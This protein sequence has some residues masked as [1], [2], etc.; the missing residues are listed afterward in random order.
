M[1]SEEFQP[2]HYSRLLTAPN[3]SFFLFGVRGSGKSTW[4]KNLG[5][6]LYE[7]NF[8]QEDLYQRFM[9][10][11]ALFRDTVSRVAQTHKQDGLDTWVFI[12]E[13][14][15]IPSL[16]NEVHD[17]IEKYHLKFILTGSSARK[18]K[19][20]GANLL[21]GR[22]LV[23]H[24]YPFVPTEL[25]NDFSL[26]EVLRFGSLP[27]IQSSAPE[28]RK[29]RLRAYVQTYLKEEIQAEALVRNLSGFMRFI[30]IAALFHGQVINISNIARDCGVERTTVS[31]YLEILHDTLLTFQLSAYE[32]KL[33]V[34]ERKHPKLFWVDP[35]IVRA[36]RGDFGPVTVDEQ[37]ALFEGWVAQTL[38]SHHAYFDDWDEMHYWAS[39]EAKGVEIDF[40]LRQGRHYL[41]IEAKSGTRIRPEWFK[42]LQAVTA[43]QGLKR[44]IL[45]YQGP[46]SLQTEEGVEVLSVSDFLKLLETRRL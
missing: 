25:G 5:R 45:V 2:I 20:G 28:E 46:D 36:A 9:A 6:S 21:A 26:E 16:L 4:V 27:L 38:R 13:I 35:G 33:R 44:R 15:R 1:T 39:T 12:D 43:L 29:E 23:K 18:L 31:G 40:L 42:G 14:Q 7:I 17:A 8:L 22:A 30:P 41:A 24:L 34:R 10:T 37:G 3:S 32:A 11:P 19:R